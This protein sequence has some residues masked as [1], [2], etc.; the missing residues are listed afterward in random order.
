MSLRRIAVRAALLRPLAPLWRT[1][2]GRGLPILMLHRFA[3]PGSEGEGFD[4]G[5]LDRGLAALSARGFQFR[6]LPQVIER[7]SAGETPS[8]AAV[9]TVDDGYRDFVTEGLPVFERWKCPVTVFLATGFQDGD[10][11][12]WDRVYESFARSGRSSIE[13]MISGE[14]FTRAR[15]GESWGDAP[16][17]LV[18]RFK[19]L[20]DR[21]RVAGIASLEQALE[22]GLPATPPSQ[23]APMSWSDAR[24]AATTGIVTF[25]PHTVSHPILSKVTDVQLTAEITRS[26]GRLEEELPPETV[27]PVFCYPNGGPEDH[28]PREYEALRASGY[29]AALTTERGLVRGE[30]LTGPSAA[31]ARYRLPRYAFPRDRDRLLQFVGGIEGWKARVRKLLR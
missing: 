16:E 1:G 22:V 19:T 18:A 25:G 26:R 17:R 28:G 24:A 8:R 3:P 15:S 31:P 4:T 7:L 10:W 11:M 20:P 14:R 5:I 30:D 27:V 2:P 23:Y 21:E 6:S 12:W 9:I 13:L 29:T